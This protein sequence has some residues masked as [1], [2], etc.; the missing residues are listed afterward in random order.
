MEL[1]VRPLAAEDFDGFINY[2]LGLSQVEIEHLGVAVDRLPS[3]ARMRSGHA[4]GGGGRKG[5]SSSC[6][7]AGVL[8]A[9]LG[10]V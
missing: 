2:W 7:R 3:T 5:K 9:A 6:P 4:I 10:S 8:T 1:S